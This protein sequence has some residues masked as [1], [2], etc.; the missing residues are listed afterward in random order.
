MGDK[1]L[2]EINYLV[3]EGGCPKMGRKLTRDKAEADR[4]CKEIEASGGQARINAY[5]EVQS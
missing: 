5:E 2:Y 4:I 3:Y 1:M